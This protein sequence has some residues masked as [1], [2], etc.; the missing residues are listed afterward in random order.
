[1]AAG[2]IALRDDCIA[3]SWRDATFRDAIR[4]EL[5]EPGNAVT[6]TSLLGDW[7]RACIIGPY[8][9]RR[10]ITDRLGAPVPAIPWS[11]SDAFWGMAF[12]NGNGEVQV[13]KTFR[14]I[15][16]EGDSS[17]CVDAGGGA[18]LV[19]LESGADGGSGF[20]HVT[21]R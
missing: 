7:R 12:T 16:Y 6:L 21:L 15:D 1:V 4:S 10:R 13:V 3:L 9:G 18:A 11:K 5:R 8:Q 19:R 17:R 14:D 2:Y 20:W